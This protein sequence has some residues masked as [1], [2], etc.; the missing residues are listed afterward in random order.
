MTALL[1][2]VVVLLSVT[3]ITLVVGLA[4]YFRRLSNA[5]REIEDTLRTI[6]ENLIPITEDARRVLRHTDSLI[7]DA[8]AQVDKIGRATQSLQ[9]ILDGRTITNV[10]ERAVST[11]RTTLASVVQSLREGLRSFKRT[12]YQSKEDAGDE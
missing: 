11:S 9:N 10:A 8:R 4:L 1:V 2:T 5:T 7:V 12:G 3:L 6:R